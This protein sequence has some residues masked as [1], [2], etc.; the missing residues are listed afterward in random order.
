VDEQLNGGAFD[1]LTHDDWRLILPM[2]REN[3]SLFGICVEEDLLTVDGIPKDPQE[4]YW[5]IIPQ[6]VKDLK[7]ETVVE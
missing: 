4:V 1:E 3:E 5:K 7:K 2:L 6:K